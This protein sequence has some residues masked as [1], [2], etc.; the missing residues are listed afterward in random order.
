DD[1]QLREHLSPTRTNGLNAMLQQMRL[2]AL[3]Y[4]QKK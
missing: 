2:F 4:A 1:I 3:T